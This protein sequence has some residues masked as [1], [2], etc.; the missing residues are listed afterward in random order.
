[1]ARKPLIQRLQQWLRPSHLTGQMIAVVLLGLGL[2]MAISFWTLGGAHRDA[3][4]QMNRGILVRQMANLTILLEDTPKGLHRAIM[5]V[6]FSLKTMN[7][8]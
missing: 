1:M 6:K 5:A 8:G 7:R 2:A 4:F 3:I